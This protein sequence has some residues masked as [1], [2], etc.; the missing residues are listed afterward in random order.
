MSDFSFPNKIKFDIHFNFAANRLFLVENT[1]NGRFLWM[2]SAYEHKKSASEP[3]CALFPV[4]Q[5][6]CSVSVCS[7]LAA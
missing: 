7:V 6:T 5:F 3:E 4:L 1:K 2:I